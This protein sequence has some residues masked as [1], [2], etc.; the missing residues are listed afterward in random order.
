MIMH[1]GGNPCD[2]DEIYALAKQHGLAVV[3]DCAH[4]AGAKYKGRGIGSHESSASLLLRPH[5]EPDV[6]GGR[7]ADLLP[8]RL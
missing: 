5:Q 1:Y 7:G 3:E 6:R 4:A 8:S 2:L